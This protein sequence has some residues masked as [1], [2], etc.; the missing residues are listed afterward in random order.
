MEDLKFGK[1]KAFKKMKDLYAD[2]MLLTFDQLCKKYLIPTFNL[3]TEV[4]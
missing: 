4:K 1:I 3:K 2:G